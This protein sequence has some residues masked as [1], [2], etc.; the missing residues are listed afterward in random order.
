VKLRLRRSDICWRECFFH[1][2]AQRGNITEP[3]AQYHSAV[4]RIS[5]AC[6]ANITIKVVRFSDIARVAGGEWYTIIP[7]RQ[8]GLRRGEE[9]PLG[10]VKN[11]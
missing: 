6:K 11:S 4:G 3:K 2:P 7:L 8:N 9:C 1:C 5:L 10:M